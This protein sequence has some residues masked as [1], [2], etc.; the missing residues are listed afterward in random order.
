MRQ[1]NKKKIYIGIICVLLGIF[2]YI[3]W[4]F[5]SLVL[6]P[7]V[8]CKKEHHVYCN[9]P[10]ELQIPFEEIKLTTSDG[11]T[12]S[13][14]FMPR[15]NSSKGLVLVHGHGGTK[16]E[17]LRFARALH[18]AG[19]NLLFLN[20]RRNQ[21]KFA[22]MGFHEVLDVQ[23]GFEY[24]FNEKKVKS[25][26]IFGFSMGASTSILAMEKDLRIKAGLFSSGYTSA[27]DVLS[28]AA[29]RDYHIPYY[30]LIP[31]VEFY[32]NLRGNMD[33]ASV[34]PIDQIGKISPRPIAI[35]HCNQDDY[36]DASHADKLFNAAKEPK[37]KWIPSCDK[38]ERIWNFYPDEANC[39]AVNFFTKYL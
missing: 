7:A 19:F 38:H 2:S 12:L 39:R 37:E 1:N 15:N 30:P 18:G 4:F 29:K 36:V 17:G 3:P 25:G 27:L 13:A 35:F 34:R 8:K 22:S 33:I 6:Y 14:W 10:S 5:S 32:L 21:G 9:G 24:L 31:V 11:V 20:L 23:A 26:G 28:E 16:A